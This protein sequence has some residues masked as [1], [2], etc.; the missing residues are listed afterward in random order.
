MR[1]T[2]LTTGTPAETS[3]RTSRC[4]CRHARTW[5]PCRESP[6]GLRGVRAA[7]LTTGTP[8]EVQRQD[9]GVCVPTNAHLPP[10]RG[11]LTENCQ[12]NLV[13]GRLSARIRDYP[14]RNSTHMTRHAIPETV[15]APTSDH[16][17]WGH[18]E[19]HVGVWT[20][21]P[22]LS[23]RRPVGSA[24]IVGS[25]RLAESTRIVGSAR[26]MAPAYAGRLFS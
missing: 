20:S 15:P 21:W 5:H 4:V 10:L 18:I 3:D 11:I 22:V 1:A 23:A 2:A 13:D 9:S 16:R 19:S 25:A 26:V 12:D 24:R 6:A 17:R 7:T 8:A 14:S